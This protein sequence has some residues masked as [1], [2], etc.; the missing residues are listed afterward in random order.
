MKRNV[1]VLIAAVLVTATAVAWWVVDRRPPAFSSTNYLIVEVV[2]TDS[3]TDKHNVSVLWN[4]QTIHPPVIFKMT[5][6]RRAPGKFGAAPGINSSTLF[7]GGTEGTIVLTPP[8]DYYCSNDAPLLL[9]GSTGAQTC[10]R[11]L[12]GPSGFFRT[13]AG[14]MRLSE[15]EYAKRLETMRIVDVSD[16]TD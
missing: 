13:Y 10:C 15:V 6:S 3:W 9:L 7:L 11:L 12:I 2:G 8:S 5:H 14:P 1:L 4:G 16:T